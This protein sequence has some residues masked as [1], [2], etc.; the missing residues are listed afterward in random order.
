TS[1]RALDPS[2]FNADKLSARSPAATAPT[3]ATPAGPNASL[4]QQG[5]TIREANVSNGETNSWRAWEA[6]GLGEGFSHIPNGATPADPNATDLPTSASDPKSDISNQK[7][8]INETPSSPS[9]SGLSTQDSALSSIVERYTVARAREHVAYQQK[10]TPWPYRHSPPQY[11]TEFRHCPCGNAC[12]CPIHEAAPFGPFPEIFWK[13]SPFGTSYAAFLEER[14]LPYRLP[15]E[16]L[17]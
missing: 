1:P 5:T 2:P 9:D 17:A 12:P 14:N 10:H 4:S 3:G 16:Y 8:E 13:L 11:I 6:T 15:Q 7:P